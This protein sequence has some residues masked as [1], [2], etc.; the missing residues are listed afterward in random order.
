VISRLQCLGAVLLWVAAASRAAVPVQQVDVIASYPHDPRAFTQGLLFTEGVLYE[1]TGRNGESTL[2]KVELATGNVLQSTALP[3]QHFGEGITLFQDKLYQ[4]TWQSHL[5]FV[6][7]KDTLKPLRSFYLPG[8]G[9]GITHDGSRLIISDGSANLRFFDPATLKEVSRIVVTEDGKPL[10]RL[11]ELEFVDGEVWANVWYTDT[12]VRI[13]PT[14]GQV[15]GKLDLHGLNEQRGVDDVLNG[16]AWDAEGKR[17]F[18]TGKL[19]SRLYE[20]KPK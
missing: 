10:D 15:V 8:E 16:I 2:R 6:Y 5:G 1:G 13:D 20:V 12:I 17:L 7:E 14:S 3:A 4:L 18:V 9:W 11:N 19:W